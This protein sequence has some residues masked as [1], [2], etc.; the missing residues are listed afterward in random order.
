MKTKA[1][2]KTI[3]KPR[4]NPRAKL[5]NV[6]AMK[7]GDE[8]TVTEATHYFRNFVYRKFRK[9]GWTYATW[10]IKVD[11]KHAVLMQRTS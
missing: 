7:V 11:G 6:E 5:W 2:N 9:L 8:M 3:R 4:W 1:N 10:S